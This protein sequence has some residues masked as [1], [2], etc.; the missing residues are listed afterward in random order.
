MNK[1]VDSVV[2]DLIEKAKTPSV[3]S[4]VQSSIL[5]PLFSTI[6]DAAYPYIVGVLCLWVIMLILLVAILVLL[7]RRKGRIE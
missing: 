6:F 3:Q 2:R 5:S 7:L 4:F 1:V